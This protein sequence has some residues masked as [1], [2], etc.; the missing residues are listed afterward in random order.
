MAQHGLLR[1]VDPHTKAFGGACLVTMP[2][3][4]L[5]VACSGSIWGR[6]VMRA[7][8][9]TNWPM[10]RS[11]CRMAMN[12]T[13]VPTKSGR[14][15]LPW[16]HCQLRY[17]QAQGDV[18]ENVSQAA[19]PGQPTLNDGNGQPGCHAPQSAK[20]AGQNWAEAYAIRFMALAMRFR[21]CSADFN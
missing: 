18:P 12:I 5:L 19:E 10:R 8:A 11:A 15:W 6:R 4:G 13:G 3:P 2:H 17:G 1:E 7:V 14:G 16:W 21:I 9:V 20:Y